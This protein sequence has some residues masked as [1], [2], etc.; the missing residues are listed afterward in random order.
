MSEN[1]WLTIIGVGEDG[2]DGLTTAS[3]AALKSAEIIMGPPRH[4]AL[5]PGGTA[6]RIEW[7]VPFRDGI[8]RLLGLRGQRVVVL[9][10]GDPFWFGAG[11]VLANRLPVGEWRALPGRSSFSLAAAQM[12]W[13]LEATI[14]LGLHAAPM[15]RL[16]P[17]LAP[18]QRIIALLRDG[19]AVRDLAD[20]LQAQGFGASMLTVMQALG[21]ASQSVSTTRADSLPDRGFSHPVCAA[22]LVAGDGAVLP[23]SSGR[24][25]DWFDHDGQI[26]KRPVRALT[27]SALAPRAGQH[28]WDIGGGSGSV[29]I[30]WLLADP[31]L[32][33]TSIEP[34]PDRAERIAGNAARLGVDRLHVITGHAPAVLTDLDRPDAVFIGGGLSVALLD[35][36]TGHLPA[37][38]KVVANAVTLESE[39]LLTQTQARLGGDLMRIEMASAAPLGPR[40]GWKSSYPITQWSHV[41]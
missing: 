39:A 18:G 22:I 5:L 34:R 26:S 1:P 16:R 19:Q 41:L 3:H 32:R 30:E 29:A 15:T 31:S 33:A 21:G 24:E 6:A 7:P 2:P 9:A 35:W 20:Y 12:G 4:L 23:L 25:D 36:L 37:G 10:S 17:H 38:T 8:D 13:G 27:L 14:C 40:R 28:L 11:T